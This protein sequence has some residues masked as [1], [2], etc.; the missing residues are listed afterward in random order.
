METFDGLY[1]FLFETFG[2]IAILLGAALLI[3][4]LACAI[5][6]KRA[7]KAL[8]ER[9]EALKDQREEDDD[10]DDDD[11]DDWDDDDE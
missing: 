5:M 1:H 11:D 8:K 6:E 3:S 9:Q 4:I 10:W 7:K 2:G